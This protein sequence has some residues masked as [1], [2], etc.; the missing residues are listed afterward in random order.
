[1]ALAINF[2]GRDVALAIGG[3]MVAAIP[4]GSRHGGD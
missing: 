4:A 1:V 3:W 2:N